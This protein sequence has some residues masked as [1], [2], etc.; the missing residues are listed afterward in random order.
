MSFEIA[1]EI[2]SKVTE[3]EEA[4]DTIQVNVIFD[5]IDEERIL[6]FYTFLYKFTSFFE[7]Y[8]NKLSCIN[9]QDEMF[10]I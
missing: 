9:R 6:Q 1:F 4:F 3:E 7:T 5:I 10:E 8:S 2:H